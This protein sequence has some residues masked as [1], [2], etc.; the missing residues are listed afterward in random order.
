MEAENRF[1]GGRMVAI[2]FLVLMGAFGLNL[3]A[4]QFFAEL[5]EIHGWS[6][7]TLSMA[8]S[9]N[10]IVWGVLQPFLGRLVDR[11]GPRPVIT[12]SAAL[13]GFA[14]LM[15]A[16]IE[17]QWEFFLYYGVLTAIGFA[18]CGSMANAV[19]ISR[20]YV[21]GRGKMLSR[22]SMGIN[23]GQL[24][25][26][27]LAGWLI[28][29]GGAGTAFAVL[30][31]GMLFL[32]A[33]LVFFGVR[34]SPSE[35]DQFPD[36]ASSQNA[37]GPQLRSATFSEAIRSFDFYCATIGFVTCGYSLYMVAMHLPG[38]AVDLGGT[39]ALGGNL[40]GLAAFASAASMWALGQI[41]PHIGKKPV[42]IG[43]YTVR[44]LALAWLAMSGQ[45]WQLYLFAVVYGA[46]SVPI[47][48]LKT[49]LIGDRFG[50]AGLG[51]IL[52]SAWF[53]HQ[54]L[55][56][57]GVYVGGAV[58]EATGGYEPAFLSAAV[59]LAVG[60]VATAAFKGV[61]EP[62]VVTASGQA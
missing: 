51:A 7:S 39:K 1:M 24:L 40:L 49:G 34:D 4:G 33:P 2:S 26:L 15:S 31:A 56:A 59:L 55:A 14:F 28:Y 47:I 29:L 35:V 61:K 23:I 13:M 38:F 53:A 8:V 37:G 60:A 30:G 25:L 6:L 54:I 12:A 10:M 36:G 18:G 42:L 52:G 45:I 5:H 20:W 43:L 19:L 3:S 22:S 41:A 50:A 44:A 27:P 46:S 58:R 17:H 16:T 48:P 11:I 57:L 32:V 9:V 62:E 21:K